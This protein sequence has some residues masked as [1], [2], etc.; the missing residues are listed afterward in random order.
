M[1]LLVI[2]YLRGIG[3]APDSI[4]TC[5]FV[6]KSDIRDWPLIGWLCE[7]GGTIFIARGKQRDVRRIFQGL[8]TSIEA[9][10][11]VAF[12]PEGTTAAQGSILPFHANLFEAALDAKV[13]VHTPCVTWMHKERCIRPRIL[14]AT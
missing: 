9:G 5:Q 13:P 3:F 12:F 14:S 1:P 6:A 4:Q 7:K 2:T 11:R 10:A 8:V